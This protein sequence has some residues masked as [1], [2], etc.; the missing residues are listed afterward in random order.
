FQ[1]ATT[2]LFQRLYHEAF[3]AYL[4]SFVYPPG[5]AEVPRWL[6]EGLAQIFETAIVEAGELR[7]GPTD[8]ERVRRVQEL[9]HKGQ[10][11]PLADLLKSGPKQ[12]LVQHATEQQI[13][14]RYY[15]S[16]WALACY[17]TF[18]RRLLAGKAMDRYV[19]ASAR[20]A[21]PAAAFRDFVGQPLS[22]FEKGFRDYLSR[23]PARATGK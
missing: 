22:E 11:V 9:A 14:D 13:S 19:Q 3:H 1:D 10:L 4:A 8:R 2:R 20:G 15:I 21:E 5:D 18:E 23:L 6:N 12:F 17:L 16:S 7:V